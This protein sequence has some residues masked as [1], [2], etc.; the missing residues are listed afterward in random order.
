MGVIFNFLLP[1]FAVI[2]DWQYDTK[3]GPWKT[4]EYF[5]N[6]GYDV[7]ACSWYDD[8]NIVS[9]IETAKTKKSCGI[10]LT[11]WHYLGNGWIGTPSIFFTGKLLKEKDSPQGIEKI[12][13]AAELLRKV[14]FTGSNY[15]SCGWVT[16]QVK[17]KFD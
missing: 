11:T 2:A 17:D 14:Y 16:C 10:M 15:E 13:N 4:S 12:L 1:K 5:K 3:K 8:D 6:K 9:A 7:I